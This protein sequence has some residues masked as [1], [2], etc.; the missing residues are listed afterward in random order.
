MANT[1]LVQIHQALLPNF[2][3][4]THERMSSMKKKFQNTLLMR[5]LRNGN[6]VEALLMTAQINMDLVNHPVPLTTEPSTSLVRVGTDACESIINSIL[7][8]KDY[9]FHQNAWSKYQIVAGV[10]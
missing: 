7:R 4:S 3:Q 6:A 10:S 8:H 5:S 2:H 1:K 9:D